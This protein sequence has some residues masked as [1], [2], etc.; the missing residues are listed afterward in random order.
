[1]TLLHLRNGHS[2]T[3]LL[4]QGYNTRIISTKVDVSKPAGV[5]QWI[6]KTVDEF[7]QLDGAANVAGIAG[8]TGNTTCETIVCKP[9]LSSPHMQLL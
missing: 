9:I 1:M 6:Q 5:Q 4:G 3:R 2:L 7:G 8:G